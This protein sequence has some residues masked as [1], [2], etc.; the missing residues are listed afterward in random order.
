MFSFSFFSTAPSLPKHLKSTNDLL[1]NEKNSDLSRLSS[2]L[3]SSPLV[4]NI[5]S[6]LIEPDDKSASSLSS[7][8]SSSLSCSSLSS[9]S[10]TSSS[11]TSSSQSTQSLS[12]SS[13]S[14]SSPLPKPQTSQSSESTC[15]SSSPVETPTKRCSSPSSLSS[16]P[17]PFTTSPS[18]PVSSFTKFE[19]KRRNQAEKQ[20]KTLRSIL[21]N[22]AQRFGLRERISST[23]SAS[24]LSP[25]TPTTRSKGKNFLR[26]ESF[27]LSY[28]DF[29]NSI[30]S[31]VPSWAGGN[32]NSSTGTSNIDDGP[33]DDIQRQVSV[34]A[35]QL[36]EMKTVDEMSSAVNK[37]YQ[38]MINRF[39]DLPIFKE[40]VQV[41]VDQLIDYTEIRLLS[42]MCNTIFNQILIEDESKDLQLQSQ[43]RNLNWITTD[44]LELDLDLSKPEICDYMDQAISHIIEMG[45]KGIP[46]QKLECIFNCSKA[47]LQLLYLSREGEPV[48][49]DLFLPALVYTVIQAN[50]PLLH[51]NIKLINQ[52][53][54]PNRLSSGEMSY[55]F[56]NLCCAVAFIEKLDG[57]SLNLSEEEFRR[58]I[59]GDERPNN[60]YHDQLQFNN[61]LSE[62]FRRMN[63]SNNLIASLS[64]KQ[65]SLEEETEQLK[66]TIIIEQES[67]LSQLK[68]VTESM[69]STVNNSNN[70]AHELRRV[71]F[72]SRVT[73]SPFYYELNRTS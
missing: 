73:Q 37:F 48:S 25:S 7:P 49:A 39:E 3:N 35:D 28:G 54:S 12:S 65:N 63:R 22:T 61:R 70:Q 44:H 60:G 29:Y 32:S 52:F 47:L 6:N 17:S 34:V 8:S 57:E 64:S 36:N 14:L 18:S 20:N 16:I 67:L 42:S 38:S 33:L 59:N 68:S 27:P 46:L 1:I 50:P 9:F 72:E 4:E 51:S 69:E 26:L 43:I 53:S 71:V 15:P 55:Y 30:G 41:S 19:E 31:V 24:S 2:I 58:Y 10:P 40:I 5:S 66:R 21:R 23:T 62:T 56:T 45:S 13:L 11:S